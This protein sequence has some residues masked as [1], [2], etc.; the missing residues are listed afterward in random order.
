VRLPFPGE[1]ALAL[2]TDPGGHT[3]ILAAPSP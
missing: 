1:P 2:R 3:V